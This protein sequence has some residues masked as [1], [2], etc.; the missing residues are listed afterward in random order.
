MTDFVEL[1]REKY[2]GKHP[3]Y[4]T[5]RDYAIRIQ[6]LQDRVARHHEQMS[7]SDVKSRAGTI[8]FSIDGAAGKGAPEVRD[9]YDLL[10]DMLQEAVN[11][12]V[13]EFYA[14]FSQSQSM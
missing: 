11:E 10:S 12:I 7:L 14:R 13:E 9:N 2:A 6:H 8:Q 5:I 4:S 3:H 1:V